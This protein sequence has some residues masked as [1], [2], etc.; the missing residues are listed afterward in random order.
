MREAELLLEAEE[1]IDYTV[2]RPGGLTNA[3]ATGKTFKVKEA[4]HVPGAVGRI[5]RA[6]RL[7]NIYIQLYTSC[8]V[9]FTNK[10][11]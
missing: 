9:V 2:V 8:L 11:C 1:D 7:D 4:G 10:I 5:G 6:W 3:A